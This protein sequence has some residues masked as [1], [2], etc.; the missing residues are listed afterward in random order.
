MDTLPREKRLEA[1]VKTAKDL[2]VFSDTQLEAFYSNQVDSLDEAL[3][4]LDETNKIPI[5]QTKSFSEDKKSGI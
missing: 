1:K 4:V 2:P 3:A 5:G